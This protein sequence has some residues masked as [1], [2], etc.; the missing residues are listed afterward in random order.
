MIINK[1]KKYQFLFEELVKRDFKKKYKRTVLGMFWSILSP[2]MMLL[3]LYLVFSSFFANTTQHYPIYLFSGNLIFSYFN[4]ATSGGMRSLLSNA[5]IFTKVN[6]PKYMFLLSRNVQALINFGLTLVV[7]FIFALFDDVIFGW[8]FLLLIYPI[9]CL[10]IFN[11]GFGMILAILY[12]LFR[13]IDYLYGLFS[14]VVMYASAIFYTINHF[15]PIYQKL[16]YANP[17]F[18]YITYFRE[19]VVSGVIPSVWLHLLCFS[20]AFIA[21]ILSAWMYKKYNQQILYYV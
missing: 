5:N 1:L 14:M 6:V 16:F 13:D 3:V 10:T 21:L 20:Y 8:H 7:Y 12:V 4:D 15:E 17:V 11:I 9:I 18:V 19:V 2:L